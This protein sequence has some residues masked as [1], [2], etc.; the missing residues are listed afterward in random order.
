MAI[1]RTGSARYEGLGKEGKGLVSTESGA[2]LNQPYGFSTRFE[3]RP[4]TNPE[5]LVGA[6][7]ASCFAMAFA[8][9]LADKGYEDGRIETEAAVTL[10]KD[11]DGFT[12]T[13]SA[14]TLKA[15]IAGI[16]EDEF[17]EIAN[18]AKANCPLSKLLNAEITLD[19]TLEG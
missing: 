3:D 4:G 6:A 12:I 9:A 5:E 7:H 16:G 18:G 14:L 13:K 19:A 11:G 1:T 15:T 2:L 17:T 8:F 10:E